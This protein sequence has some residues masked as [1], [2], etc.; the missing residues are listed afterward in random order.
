MNR[1]V[2]LMSILA[3]ALFAWTGRGSDEQRFMFMDEIKPGMEGYGKT[4]I[5]GD[6]IRAFPIKV[7]GVIDNP[8]DLDDHI[9][10]RASGDVIREA[11]GIAAGMSG[12]PIYINDKLIGALWGA[13]TFDISNTPIALIRPIQTML[14]LTDSIRAKA[15][16]R[17]SY[18]SYSQAP[19]HLG[20]ISIDGTQKSVEL[21][22]VEPTA[23][24]RAAHPNTLYVRPVMTPVMV[25][26]ISGRAMEWF[27]NGLSERTLRA[28]ASTLLNLKQDDFFREME[29]GFEER[30]NVKLIQSPVPFGSARA[31]YTTEGEKPIEEGS[32]LSALLTYGDISLGAIGTVSYV[33][34]PLFLAFGHPFLFDG[35]VEFFLADAKIIDTVESLEVP[36]KLGVPT[37]ARGVVFEDRMQGIGGMAGI[38]PRH[39]D[40]EINVK[41]KDLGLNRK[42]SYQIGYH[43]NLVPFLLFASALQAMDES[44]NRIGPGTMKITYTIHGR[45][46]PKTLTHDDVLAS[47][48]DVA[49]GGPLRA[50]QTLFLL[51]RNEFS[52]PE[53][54]K[55][56]IDIQLER[57][58]HAMRVK[59]IKTDKDKY[60][61]GDTVKYTV[62]VQPYRNKAQTI[63]GTLELPKDLDKRSS[64]TLRA[65]GGPKRSQQRSDDDSPEFE[66]LDDLVS[67]LEDAS[68]NDWV[69]VEFLGLDDNA[70]DTKDHKAKSENKKKEKSAGKVTDRQHQDGWFVY[71]EKSLDLDIEEENNPPKDEE[72]A[73][74]PSE[75]GKKPEEQQ[76]PP[77]KKC[78]FLF[79]C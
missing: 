29:R 57:E 14:K 23:A 50:A 24:E 69:T 36:W 78:K 38:E 3:L 66:S 39:I 21:V 17:A 37:K 62:T 46:M 68:A 76:P 58:V 61:P 49:V 8:G 43:E 65:F 47:F 19:A 34:G 1:K 2:L 67:A 45:K 33:D 63:E 6:E 16:D 70:G 28:F 77:N 32:A 22:S 5:K 53:L 42:I 71:G 20:D 56:T 13:A 59:S 55:V 12:S 9:V 18:N 51:T 72:P 25:S 75:P 52:D 41:N 40:V 10:V 60:K 4:I 44:L 31:A 30:Y 7:I 11:G 35:D 15:Q 26:G 64:L 73:T 48:A 27:K 74:K 79:Y 54:D